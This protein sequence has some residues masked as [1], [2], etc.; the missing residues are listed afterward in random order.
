[1]QEHAPESGFFHRRVEG[2]ITILLIA[3]DGVPSVRGVHTN[4]VR[5]PGMQGDFQQ[6]RFIAE[7]L[8]RSELAD[9]FLARRMH[10]HRALT[11]HASVREQSF[12]YLG[13]PEIPVTF[14]EREIALVHLPFTHQLMKRAKCAALAGN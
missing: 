1:M 5:A 8:D 11:A 2:L 14:D 13:V 4:L 9:R 6:R 3:R 12:F 7:H 10:L